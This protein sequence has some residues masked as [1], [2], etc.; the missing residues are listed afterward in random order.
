MANPTNPITGSF[1]IQKYRQWRKKWRSFAEYEKVRDTM[2]RIKEQMHARQTA[3]ILSPI[4]DMV[5]GETKS[6]GWDIE[7]FWNN[8]YRRY[9]RYR[10]PLSDGRSNL[11]SSKIYAAIEAFMAEFAENNTGV[12]IQPKP[13]EPQA[14]AAIADAYLKALD[15][16]GRIGAEKT[17]IVREAAIT[18]TAYSYNCF[19]V[20]EQRFDKV[21]TED[22]IA[23]EFEKATPEEK[24]NYKKQLDAGKPVTKEMI[25]EKYKDAAILYVPNTEIYPD[26]AARCIKGLSHEAV[27]IT[28]RQIYSYQQF[29]QEFE[30]SKDPFI[31]KENVKKVMPAKEAADSYSTDNRFF[32]LPEDMFNAGDKVVVYRYYNK[33][34]NK[35]L[36][37]VND[38]LIREGGLP[39]NHGELPFSRYIVK[40]IPGQFYG[41]GY[42]Y[43]LEDIQSE[44]ETYRNL[45]IEVGK[46]NALR[47]VYATPAAYESIE[48][49]SGKMEP[50]QIYEIDADLGASI[51]MAE[52][53]SL[54]NEFAQTQQQLDDEAIRLTGI[55]PLMQA[56]P[57]PN[58]PVR[59]N[60][61]NVE[62]SLKHINK[63]ISTLGEGIVDA[64]QQALAI[65]QQYLPTMYKESK[66]MVDGV[67]IKRKKYSMIEIEDAEI[68]MK[69]DG[70]L[71]MKDIQGK[72]VLELN[73]DY[74][75]F[76]AN[77]V[78]F[79]A[80][81]FIKQ[82]KALQAQEARETMLDSL[83]IAPNPML[84][85]NPI[86]REMYR[87]YLV[88]RGTSYKVVNKIQK[89]DTEE[90][91]QDAVIQ[92]KMM[93]QGLQIPGMPGMSDWH[94]SVH[95]DYILELQSQKVQLLTEMNEL[96]DPEVPQDISIPE[97]LA[98]QEQVMQET[99][100]IK[101]QVKELDQL[102]QRVQE[103]LA[104]D[105]QVKS[106]STQIALSIPT[107]PQMPM[108]PMGG[109]PMAQM[110]GDSMQ[111]MM[112]PQ[113]AQPL[114]PMGG[115]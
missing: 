65:A 1:D 84:M 25:L 6:N 99:E 54:G 46:W 63:D 12:L 100:M 98:M 114:N 32:E 10:V 30:Q 7:T 79:D 80:D 108:S 18:G 104:V 3:C 89:E 102:M 71:D 40:E 78:L 87:D 115:I 29:V 23:K 13:G 49:Q 93:E 107:T 72:S 5:V 81:T 94:Q 35:F 110:Q 26:P 95:A 42:A 77:Y 51:Q 33:A 91:Q 38:I 113:E 101:S 45:R 105:S 39:Y 37:I 55:S 103:H 9:L 83:Q 50:N 88:K 44:D 69:E 70:E 11:K 22:E 86:I 66:E 19:V 4:G 62:S 109:D 60:M 59:N 24:A 73:P 16:K 111:A 31:I 8:C 112:M 41:M 74:V 36:I 48:S 68:S 67:E 17:K 15:L 57:R 90:S 2:N 56:A 20:K 76:T 96:S 75:D 85:N 53:K 34:T 43:L 28:W 82:S 27:D 21:L 106:A 97:A 52:A 47:P 14:Q 64:Y 92:N 61:M 58:T